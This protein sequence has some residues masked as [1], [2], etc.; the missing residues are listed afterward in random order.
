MR[1]LRVWRPLSTGNHYNYRGLGDKVCVFYVS[2]GPWAPETLIIIRVLEARCAYFTC[3]EALK[4]L[5]TIIII[6]SWRQG[7]R[8][9]RVWRPSGA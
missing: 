1:I 4:A 5:E 8:I 3:L 6:G 9:L 2:G 7:V